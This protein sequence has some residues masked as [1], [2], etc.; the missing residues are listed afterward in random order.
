MIHLS[1]HSKRLVSGMLSLLKPLDEKRSRQK[2]SFSARSFSREQSTYTLVGLYKV[3]LTYGPNSPINSRRHRRI[4]DRNLPDIVNI[5]TRGLCLP[6]EA[7][8][9]EFHSLIHSLTH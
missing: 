8:S 6:A 5:G 3:A 2:F 7:R 1:V 9:T 4:G